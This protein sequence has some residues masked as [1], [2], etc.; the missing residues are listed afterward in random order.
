M[1]RKSKKILEGLKT[2]IEAEMTGHHFYKEAAKRTRDPKG[3]KTFSSM[4]DE[5]MGHFNYLRHQYKSI[6]ENGDLL[7]LDAD[8]E[9][10]KIRKK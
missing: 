9:I 10:I 6:L 5:E 1:D 7:E 4:A 3:K 8:S 2:A